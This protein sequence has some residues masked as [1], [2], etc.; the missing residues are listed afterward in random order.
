MLLLASRH[1]ATC[2]LTAR[3][4]RR[5]LPFPPP[6]RPPPPPPPTRHHHKDMSELGPSLYVFS[7]VWGGGASLGGAVCVCGLGGAV[8]VCVRARAHIGVRACGLR[9]GLAYMAQRACP[10]LPFL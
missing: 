4:R 10:V 6:P 3:P 1:I 2:G 8:F 7:S 5:A 9:E